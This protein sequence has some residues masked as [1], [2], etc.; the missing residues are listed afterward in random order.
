MQQTVGLV[1]PLRLI[2]FGSAARGDCGSESDLDLLVVVPEGTPCRQTA[3]LLHQRLRGL[4]RPVDF[5][6]ATPSMLEK[7]RH[8]IGLIYKSILEEGKEVYVRPAP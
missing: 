5:I 7:H 6:V 1:R 4:G 2:L 8:N 3:Q